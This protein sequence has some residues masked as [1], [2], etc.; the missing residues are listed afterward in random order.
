MYVLIIFNIHAGI[1]VVP[2]LDSVPFQKTIAVLETYV[3]LLQASKVL[4]KEAAVRH[5]AH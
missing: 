5:E 3:C 1:Y 4:M 2:F